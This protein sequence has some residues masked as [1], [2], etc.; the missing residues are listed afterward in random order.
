MVLSLVL[1]RLDRLRVLREAALALF[2]LGA[3]TD[4]VRASEV[5]A[6]VA[7]RVLREDSGWFR[8]ELT[9][10]LKLAGW[11]SV[12]KGNVRRWCGIRRRETSR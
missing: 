2:E 10:A 9:E 5:A 6:A 11:R 3:P 12:R 1:Q 8:R 7:S 4:R